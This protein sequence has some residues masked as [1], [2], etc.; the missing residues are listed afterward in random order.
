MPPEKVDLIPG[1]V[2]TWWACS[3]CDCTVYG[4]GDAPDCPNCG[5]PYSPQTTGETVEVIGVSNS[6][7][8]FQ[9]RQ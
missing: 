4:E 3:F 7:D 8:P 1:K 5:K 6:R 2:V 9:E